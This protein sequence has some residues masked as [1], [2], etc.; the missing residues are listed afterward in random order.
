M[1]KRRNLKKDGIGIQNVEYIETRKTVRK[2]MRED[3]RKFNTQK[4][5]ETIEN[6]GSLKK[7]NKKL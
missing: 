4:I 5:Q 3:I 1:D 2:K 7:T 6:N